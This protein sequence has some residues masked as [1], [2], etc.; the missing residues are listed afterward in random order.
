VKH[1]RDA[2]KRKLSKIGGTGHQRILRDIYGS[3]DGITKELGLASSLDKDDFQA[4][5]SS[6]KE[7]W[8]SLTDGFHNWFSRN[9]ASKFIECVIESARESSGIEDLFYNNAI[10]SLHSS[11]K[12]KIS[13]KK[14]VIELIPFIESLIKRQRLEEERAI[15]KSG[16]WRLSQEY[17]CF[18]M[19]SRAWYAMKQHE[20]DDHVA[21]FRKYIP[22]T[23]DLYKISGA[24]GRKPGSQTSRKRN[25]KEPVFVE[26]RV[27]PSKIPKLCVKKTGDQFS[28]QVLKDFD[29]SKI[30]PKAKEEKAM[31][32]RLKSMHV[33]VSSCNA[34]ECIRK[35]S[36]EKD[37][38][39]IQTSGVSVWTD[40]KRKVRSRTGT[41]YVHFKE[42]CLRQVFPDFSYEKIIVDEETRKKLPDNAIA[43]LASFGVNVI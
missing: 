21:R 35:I 23:K 25:L 4:K 10:E 32:L 42:E 9:R 6:L 39:I 30:N 15:T 40:S 37:L 34:A 22:K 26:E 43:R 1:I 14:K 7:I 29:L 31:V 19:D 41:V 38:L 3:N 17:K 28:S 33:N 20:R 18:E 36:N 12:S 11:L 5:L 27:L 8:D 24:V 16:D 2:D 13:E